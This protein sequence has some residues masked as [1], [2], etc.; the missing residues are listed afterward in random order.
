VK[1]FLTESEISFFFTVIVSLCF[2]IVY[3][4]ACGTVASC[5]AERARVIVV[6]E[7]DMLDISSVKCRIVAGSFE[8]SCPDDYASKVFQR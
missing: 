8:L 6:V 3:I 4:D 5:M 1:A 7:V 2:K